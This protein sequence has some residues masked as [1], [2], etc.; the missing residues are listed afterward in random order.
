MRK[1]LAHAW[2]NLAD[3]LKVKGQIAS[4]CLWSVSTEIFLRS[5]LIS[6]LISSLSNFRFIFSSLFPLSR[7]AVF[8]CSNV[9]I[10]GGLNLR[11]LN[12]KQHEGEV[13]DLK[14]IRHL[15]PYDVLPAWCLCCTSN[16]AVSVLD[17][18]LSSQ[19]P[20]I[21]ISLNF[22]TCVCCTGRPPYETTHLVS[23][24]LDRLEVTSMSVQSQR[25]GFLLFK[26]STAGV[27][28]P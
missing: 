23:T 27:H 15:M 11:R 17:V 9:G 13:R 26:T 6:F 19:A 14:V 24:E 12:Q 8:T 2:P 16:R 4:E 7:P 21:C 1:L 28:Q 5:L 20:W 3:S 10:L 22:K 18:L 25:Q